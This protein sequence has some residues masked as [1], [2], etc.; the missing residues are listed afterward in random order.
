MPYLYCEEHGREHEAR[1]IGNQATFRQ[2]G[3]GVLIV[4]G[5]LT[6]GPWH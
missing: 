4:H 1:V 3:E 6:S 2:A 5:R